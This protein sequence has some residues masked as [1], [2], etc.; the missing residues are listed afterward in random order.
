VVVSN[1]VLQYTPT[2]HWGF[3]PDAGVVMKVVGGDWK[4]EH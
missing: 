4:L 2:D 1:G 3:Q